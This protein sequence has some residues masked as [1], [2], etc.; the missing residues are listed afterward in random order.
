MYRVFQV[1]IKILLKVATGVY[2]LPG[3]HGSCSAAHEP[4]GK[5]ESSITK[6]YW[7]S[8]WKALYLPFREITYTKIPQ[9]Y[10]DQW[11]IMIIRCRYGMWDIA[12]LYVQ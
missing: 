3:L 12:L 8:D 5:S 6:T 1:L 9:T 10:R 2:Y 4:N 11:S 7:T